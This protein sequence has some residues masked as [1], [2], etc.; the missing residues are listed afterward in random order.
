MMLLKPPFFLV[1][2]VGIS[3]LIHLL[4]PVSLS[5]SP[6]SLE[7]TPDQCPGLGNLGPPSLDLRNFGCICAGCWQFLVVLPSGYYHRL[8]FVIDDF[9]LIAHVWCRTF[10]LMLTLP[11]YSGDSQIRNKSPGVPNGSSNLPDEY[12]FEPFKDFD[13]LLAQI[14]YPG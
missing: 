11:D 6:I 2:R 1:D 13:P 5:S 9:N 7:G 10:A 14:V 8:Y 4:L 3:V 12:D